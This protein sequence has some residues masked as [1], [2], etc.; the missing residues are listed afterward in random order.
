MLIAKA[1][2]L[3]RHFGIPLEEALAHCQADEIVRQQI[4]PTQNIL[5]VRQKQGTRHL[6]EGRWGLVPA[7]AKSV[8]DFQRTFNAR[9]ET[10]ARLPIFRSGWKSRRCLIPASAFWEWQDIGTRKKVKYRIH[11]PTDELLAFAGLWESWK[12]PETSQPLVSTTILTTDAAGILRQIHPRVP[13][14]LGPETWDVW[15]SESELPADWASQ[16]DPMSGQATL[17]ADKDD[18]PTSPS[19]GQGLFWGAE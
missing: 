1:K 2:D 7:W 8:K 5:F 11:S 17:R 9:W 13:V 15:L 14:L 4:V 6:A 19:I 10:A 3:A 12:N 16:F 18:Q